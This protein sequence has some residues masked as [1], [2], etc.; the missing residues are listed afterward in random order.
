MDEVTFLF[1][2]V[3][4]NRVVTI[5]CALLVIGAIWRHRVWIKK[6]LFKRV[7]AQIPAHAKVS[8]AIHADI[9]SFNPSMVLSADGNIIAANKRTQKLFG[10]HEEELVNNKMDKII[11]PEYMEKFEWLRKNSNGNKDNLPVEEVEA[12]NRVGEKVWLKISVGKWTDDIEIFFTVTMQ[13]VTHRVKNQL[14]IKAAEEEINYMR[15]LYHEGEKVGCVGF[16]ELNT[17]TGNLVFS[18]NYSHIMGI[19]GLPVTVEN[20]IKRIIAEDKAKVVDTMNRARENKTGFEVDYRLLSMD[21]YLATIHTEAKAVK[22]N[23]GEL[24]HYIGMTRLIK[25]EKTSWL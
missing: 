10:W 18:P 13:D 2:D 22:N 7:S 23:N 14:A 3:E 6:H 4:W 15:R 20:V 9:F 19:K 8:Q 11:L 12:V 24:T 17:R 21:G 1:S 25:K 16:W 5:I